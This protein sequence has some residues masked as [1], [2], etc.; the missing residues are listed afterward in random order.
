MSCRRIH[1]PAIARSHFC[2]CCLQKQYHIYSEVKRHCFFCEISEYCDAFTVLPAAIAAAN[3][4]VNNCILYTCSPREKYA[5]PRLHL[6]KNFYS[7]EHLAEPVA[8]GHAEITNLKSG[9]AAYTQMHHQREE[10]VLFSFTTRR[11]A[12]HHK[13]HDYR[14]DHCHHHDRVSWNTNSAEHR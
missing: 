7:H 13:H 14:Y 9:F 5:F 6:I 10:R 12:D 1:F 4:T 2:L 8:A 3:E 11:T